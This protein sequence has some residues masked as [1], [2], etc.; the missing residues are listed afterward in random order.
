MGKIQHGNPDLEVVKQSIRADL[1]GAKCDTSDIILMDVTDRDTEAPDLIVALDGERDALRMAKYNVKTERYV[2]P[3][4]SIRVEI[5]DGTPWFPHGDED[6][7]RDVHMMEAGK[8]FAKH[9]ARLLENGTLTV[10]NLVATKQEIM[11]GMVPS[12]IGREDD[13]YYYLNPATTYRMVI[14]NTEGAR[15]GSARIT[16]CGMK[17]LGLLKG[18]NKSGCTKVCQ[19]GNRSLRC[20]WVR[21][22]ELNRYKERK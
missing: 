10:I 18:D 2:M 22:A 4:N 7:G 1:F 21:K 16:M 3:V 13:Q 17:K 8:L 20:L 5:E 14:E 15:F 11:D 6:S 9:L 19:Y 12:C